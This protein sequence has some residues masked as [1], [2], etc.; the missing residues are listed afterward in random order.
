M[1]QEPRL[2]TVEGKRKTTRSKHADTEIERRDA[3]RGLL[4]GLSQYFPLGQGRKEWNRRLL[5]LQGKHGRGR[6]TQDNLPLT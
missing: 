4:Q 6:S 5:L 1:S 2:R 3:E